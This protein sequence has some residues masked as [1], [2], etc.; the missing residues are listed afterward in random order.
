MIER[1]RQI[2][3][4]TAFVGLAC[5]TC[6]GAMASEGEY[7][8]RTWKSFTNQC[9]KFF[10]D[11]EAFVNNL[12]EPGPVGERVFA[13][14]EDGSSFF[15]DTILDD[16]L[17]SASIFVVGNRMEVSCGSQTFFHPGL[18]P[19]TIDELF[20]AEIGQAT[21]IVMTGG[22]ADRDGLSPPPNAAKHPGET[23]YIYNATGVFD[24]IETIT[25]V[26][27]GHG[28]FSAVAGQTI[29]KEGESE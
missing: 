17:F 20:Q 3:R 28:Y 9:E 10:V 12:A 4:G 24:G 2:V 22:T 11:R 5:G 7:I 19:E 25:T 16:A 14:T 29:F 26:N 13:K 18:S 6:N 27:F 8:A 1:M 21:D 23:M 15:I